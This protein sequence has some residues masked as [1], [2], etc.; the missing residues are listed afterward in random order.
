MLL[1][2]RPAAGIGHSLLSYSSTLRGIS[3]MQLDEARL[4]QVGLRTWFLF[5]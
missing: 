4:H 5:S 2:R 3:K 1:L